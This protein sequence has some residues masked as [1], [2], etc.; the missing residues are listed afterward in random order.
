MC[1]LDGSH[2][3][4]EQVGNY[5]G[6]LLNLHA[7]SEFDMSVALDTFWEQISTPVPD[8]KRANDRKA[9]LTA[10]AIRAFD[11]EF[12]AGEREKEF[13]RHAYT[14]FQVLEGKSELGIAARLLDAETL[15]EMEELLGRVERWDE[16]PIH[17]L[18]YALKQ[19]CTF[20]LP[21]KP[22]NIEEMDLLA[23]QIAT[24][25]DGIYQHVDALDLTNGNPQV[26]C[27]ARALVLAAVQSYKWENAEQ[28]LALARKFAQVEHSFLPLCYAPEAFQGETLRILPPFHR[29]G[30]YCDQAFQTLDSG[31]AV[32]YVRLLREGL[33]TCKDMKPMVEFLIEHTEELN[34]IPQASPELLALAERVRTI[35]AVYAPDDPAVLALKQSPAYQ[36][37]AYLIEEPASGPQ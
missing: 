32:G 31:N 9:A 4:P 2:M 33:D 35:L 1:Q 21:E 20:P 37:V 10:T 14:A 11:P 6:L 27:W 19:D 26:V 25:D 18:L 29:F 16:F 7:Q 36:Q 23:I 30:W 3:T 13:P 24:L 34:P 12:Q 22:L 28:G 8:Q 17:A 15:D 5:L